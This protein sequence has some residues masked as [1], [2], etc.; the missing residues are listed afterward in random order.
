MAKLSKKT[1][2]MRRSL[3]KQK[4]GS[5]K[6]QRGGA[7]NDDELNKLQSMMI[8]FIESKKVD[9]ELFISLCGKCSSDQLNALQEIV[10]KSNGPD[11]N[12]ERQNKLV[13]YILFLKELD[14]QIE[15]INRS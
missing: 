10:A 11:T 7:L 13:D 2:T 8:D 6:K 15:I 5:Y 4:G 14:K 3:K 12:N 1:K 9:K